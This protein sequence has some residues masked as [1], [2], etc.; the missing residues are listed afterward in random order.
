VLYA[1]PEVTRGPSNALQVLH[2]A[3]AAALD[4]FAAETVAAE[5]GA[6]ETAA[7]DVTA[8]SVGDRG[9]FAAAERSLLPSPDL[10]PDVN[11][12]AA[13]APA[14]DTGGRTAEQAWDRTAEAEAD[15]EKPRAARGQQRAHNQQGAKQQKRQQ[16]KP[17]KRT[18]TPHV[19]VS[20]TDGA[21]ESRAGRAALEAWWSP[22]AFTVDCVHC[23]AR[24]GPSG[25]FTLR[26]RVPLGRRADSE[27]GGGGGG[28]VGGGSGGDGRYGSGRGGGNVAGSNRASPWG[29]APS[30]VPSPLPLQG[31]LQGEPLLCDAV[32][33]RDNC[34]VPFM[35]G[36]NAAYPL[37]LTEVSWA[38]EVALRLKQRQQ[39]GRRKEKG[40]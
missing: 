15:D 23:M 6:A 10:C 8:T 16:K 28:G 9:P 25:A 37:M 40:S 21:E 38:A 19:T 4:A 2:A 17:Q 5:G 13:C 36:L 31:V 11:P 12:A 20:H 24:D 26:W 22:V 34:N 18:F 39:Q 3:C 27:G 14:Q 7:A 1:V 33:P 29:S 35:V 32:T 30:L